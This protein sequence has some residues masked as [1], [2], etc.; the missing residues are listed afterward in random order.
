MHNRILKIDVANI[1]GLESFHYSFPFEPNGPMCNGLYGQENEGKTSLVQTLSLLKALGCGVDIRRAKHYFLNVFH[2]EGC[3]KYTF[4]LRVGNQNYHVHYE[5]YLKSENETMFTL[6]QEKLSYHYPDESAV[7]GSIV[8]PY[9]PNASMALDQKTLRIYDGYIEGGSSF[10]FAEDYLGYLKDHNQE[11]FEVVKALRAQIISHLHVVADLDYFEDCFY[12]SCPAIYPERFRETSLSRKL[13]DIDPDELFYYEGVATRVCTFLQELGMKIRFQVKPGVRRFDGTM[14][15]LRVGAWDNS[16]FE[17]S[18]AGKSIK[19]LIAFV[20]GYVEVMMQED[21]WLVV[22][23]VD[24]KSFHGYAA[25]FIDALVGMGN[26]QMI[27]TTDDVSLLTQLPSHRA[28]CFSSLSLPAPG[29]SFSSPHKDLSREQIYN[30]ASVAKQ[31][32]L[33]IGGK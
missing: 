18:F 28:G 15:L 3:V 17:A 10:L 9:G 12:G 7:K 14:E 2:V 11:D 23:D 22:D 21:E 1:M 19:K 16:V 25:S 26:G 30:A 8:I 29:P 4:A 31:A 24:V 33:E 6:A 13:M 32:E 20:Q 27:F 5:A